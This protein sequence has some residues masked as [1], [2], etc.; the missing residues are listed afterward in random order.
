[1]DIKQINEQLQQFFEEQETYCINLFDAGE[2]KELDFITRIEGFKSKEEAEEFA[3]KKYGNR[4]DIEY[5]IEKQ[6]MESNETKSIQED[7]KED[8]QK[9]KQDIIKNIENLSVKSKDIDFEKI[10]EDLTYLKLIFRQI[11]HGFIK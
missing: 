11:K 10:K 8:T 2:G 5:Q 9:I 7:I 1:M 3:K 6:I 4:T